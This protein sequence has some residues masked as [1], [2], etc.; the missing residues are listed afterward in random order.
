LGG[1]KY[2]AAGELGLWAHAPLGNAQTWGLYPSGLV[3]DREAETLT[4]VGEPHLDWDAVLN[5]EPADPELTVGAWSEDDLDF[6]AGVAAVRD[7]ILDGEV[8]QVNLSRGVRATAQGD[9][10]AGYLR[11]AAMNPSPF[12]AYVELGDEVVVSCSP[13]RLALWTG[14]EVSAR[15][16]AGTRRRGA[17]EEEDDALEAELRASPKERAEHV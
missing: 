16:I 13:E 15:P 6:P 17:T 10:L 9:P 11:L 5:A 14:S 4:V 12:M 1:L 3:W 7:L 2:E 8:Y